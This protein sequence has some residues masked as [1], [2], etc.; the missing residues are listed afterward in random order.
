MNSPTPMP[1]FVILWI[2]F[3]VVTLLDSKLISDQSKQIEKIQEEIN[4]M[5]APK[6]YLLPDE[7]I[8]GPGRNN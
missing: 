7:M 6:T 1:L 4:E 8:D 2:T 3:L 5:K